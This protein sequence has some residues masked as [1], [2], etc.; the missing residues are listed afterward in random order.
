MK[1]HDEYGHRSLVIGEFGPT[2]SRFYSTIGISDRRFGIPE[3]R[4]EFAVSGALPWLPNALATSVFWLW[5]RGTDDWPLVCEDA[6][7]TNV[8]STYRHM[9][10][11]PSAY[12]YPLS[13]GAPVRWLLGVPLRESELS[14]GSEALNERIRKVF[15][16][17]LVDGSTP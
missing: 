10:Y 11:L 15:P 13:K 17:W 1:Y 3:G 5:D 8:R 7:K 4:F 16:G 12:E 9:G 14:F 2:K 6:V